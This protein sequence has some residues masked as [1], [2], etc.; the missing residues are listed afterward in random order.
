MEGE[1]AEFK[2]KFERAAK[3]GREF[4]QLVE[5]ENENF[6]SKSFRK[7]MQAAAAELSEANNDLR[8]C[9]E[10]LAGQR[11]AVLPNHRH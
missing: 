4:S 7:K 1:S 5:E 11:K 10:E 6:E 9:M 8:A 3:L 2:Q